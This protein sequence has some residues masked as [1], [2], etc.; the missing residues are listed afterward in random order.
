MKRLLAF[1]VAAAM[2]A[3]SIYVRSRMDDDDGGAGSPTATGDLRVVCSDELA[4][5]CELVG[6]RVEDAGTTADRLVD[7]DNPDVDVWIAPAP[8]PELVDVRRERDGGDALFGASAVVATTRL[9]MVS[10]NDALTCTGEVSWRCV[11]DAT[12]RGVKPGFADPTR[13][14]VG[15]L[16]LGHLAVSL[17]GRADLSTIDLED[18]AFDDAFLAIVRAV[19]DYDDDPLTRMLVQGRSAY[20]VVEV[21]GAE[22]TRILA[23]AARRNEVQVQYP[24]PVATAGAVVAA[25]RGTRVP[26]SLRDRAASALEDAGWTRGG[27]TGGLPDAGFLDA[28]V[29]RWAEVVG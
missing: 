27:R 7:D 1:V 6:G 8:W 11:A 12:A 5:V 10:W 23:T 17:A 19:S 24:A 26:D 9:A 2:V 15:L 13:N 14:G 20:D 3:G 16:A 22:A 25:R 18:P 21:A 28:L 29:T 4:T